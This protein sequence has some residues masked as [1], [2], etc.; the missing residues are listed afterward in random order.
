MRDRLGK[1]HPVRGMS[2]KAVTMQRSYPTV[3]VLDLIWYAT[4]AGGLAVVGCDTQ[5]DIDP[6]PAVSETVTADADG[7]RL[8][9]ELEVENGTDPL[10]VGSK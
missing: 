8:S 9:D 10:D 3:A 2:W 7:D 4:F 1:A 6:S 5:V